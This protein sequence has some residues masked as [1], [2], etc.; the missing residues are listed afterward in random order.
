[1]Y[2]LKTK[3]IFAFSCVAYTQKEHEEK[4]Q[5]ALRM[6][7]LAQGVAGCYA[8]RRRVEP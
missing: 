4:V 5:Q 1:M 8:S 3:G 7:Y 6:E 2:A